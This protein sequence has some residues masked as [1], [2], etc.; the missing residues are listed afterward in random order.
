MGL[1]LGGHGPPPPRGLSDNSSIC[2]WM[3]EE[4]YVSD[5]DDCHRAMAWWRR[6]GIGENLTIHKW[7]FQGN[8]ELTPC[9]S[10]LSYNA[11]RVLWRAQ[12]DRIR[13]PG[14]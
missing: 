8:P 11:Q 6:P 10:V 3:A 1:C 13:L 4:S 7:R 9:Q 5:V 14:A 12:M 2:S